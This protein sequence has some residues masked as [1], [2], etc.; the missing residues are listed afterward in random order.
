MPAGAAQAPEIAPPPSPKTLI[1]AFDITDGAQ[2]RYLVSGSARGTALNQFAFSEL[3]G[4]LRVATT[5]GDQSYVSVLTNQDGKLL[6]QIGQVGGLGKGDRIYAVRFIGPLAYVVTFRQTD[7]LYVVDLHTPTKPR[8]AGEL[9]LLGYSAY[10]HPVGDNLLIGVGQDAT[11]S[12]QR[13]GTQV[14]LFDV[15]NPA[16]PKLLQ[17]HALGQGGS[18][19]EYDHHAFLYWAPKQLA[20]IPLQ[21]YSPNGP[22]FMGAVGMRMTPTAIT[23]V[24]RVSQQYDMITRSLV[25]GDHLFTLSNSGL[26]ENDLNSFAAQA[27]VSFGTPGGASGGGGTGAPGSSPASPPSA[28]G[29]PAR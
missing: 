17:R 7:P 9:K 27:F 11:E 3:D 4:N 19:A 18:Q 5:D 16:A 15:S 2:A 25:I 23:E 14:S 28:D 20:V 13:L 10:L 22:G 26:G 6:G 24:G 12:G 29:G 21:E 1:H 8:V